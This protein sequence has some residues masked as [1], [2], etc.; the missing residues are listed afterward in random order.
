MAIRLS[1]PGEALP[2][3]RRSGRTA[4]PAPSSTGRRLFCS[5]AEVF[6]L[7]FYRLGPAPR[8][9]GAKTLIL[10][11]IATNICVLFTAND[12][13]R[14]GFQLFVPADCC[15]ANELSNHETALNL[16]EKRAESQHWRFAGNSL[17]Q[18]TESQLLNPNRPKPQLVQRTGRQ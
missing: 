6:Q 8:R 17:G 2:S 9:L 1:C 16:M 12:A 3:G 11:G 13:Y 4:R 18:F 14:R 7:L 5:E 10:T 15:A